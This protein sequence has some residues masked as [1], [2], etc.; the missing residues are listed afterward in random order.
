MVSISIMLLVAG[1]ILVRQSGFNGAVLLE[2][3]AYEIALATREVQVN[4]VSASAIQG[5][6]RE[7]LGVYFDTSRRTTYRIFRDDENNGSYDASEEYG[8]QNSLDSRFE[9][10]A[11]RVGCSNQNSVAVLFERPNFDAKFYIGTT[12][13]AAS[14]VEIDVGVKDA[15]SA[16]VKTVIVTTTGQISVADSRCN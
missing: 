5:T 8:Q 4:A 14:S 9:I 2:G 6:V 7:M 11:I 12:Q 13:V 16:D 15:S 1:V 3:Q 10:K